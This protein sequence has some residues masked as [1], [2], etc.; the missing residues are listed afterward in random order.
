MEPGDKFKFNKIKKL[1][2]YFKKKSKN[3]FMGSGCYTRAQL[4]PRCIGSRMIAHHLGMHL[5][6]PV[7]LGYHA[8]A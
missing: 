6:I 1:I 3:T 5:G 4:L 7:D 8:R 2:S